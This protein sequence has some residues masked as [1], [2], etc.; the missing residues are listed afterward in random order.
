M[1]HV[2]AEEPIVDVGLIDIMYSSSRRLN[3]T[4]ICLAG[5]FLTVTLSLVVSNFCISVSN[6][7]E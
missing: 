6:V 4:T 2:Q 1:F 5:A 7:G 3:Y